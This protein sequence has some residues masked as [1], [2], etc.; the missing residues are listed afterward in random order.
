MQLKAGFCMAVSLWYW[1]ALHVDS[2]PWRFGVNLPMHGSGVI[3]GIPMELSLCMIVSA[4]VCL[5]VTFMH[6]HMG[7]SPTHAKQIL[8]NVQQHGSTGSVPVFRWLLCCAVS[9][10]SLIHI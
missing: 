1:C 4:N 5:D 6:A 7:S 2:T 10:L 8:Y 3:A 9:V